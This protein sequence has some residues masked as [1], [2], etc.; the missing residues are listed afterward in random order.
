MILWSSRVEEDIKPENFVTESANQI[1]HDL[2]E[3]IEP[4]GQGK[5]DFPLLERNKKHRTFRTQFNEF[6]INWASSV[7]P[8]VKD[9]ELIEKVILPWLISMTSAAYRPIRYAATLAILN[10]IQGCCKACVSMHKDLETASRVMNSSKKAASLASK[11]SV[12]TL[13]GNCRN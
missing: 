5:S 8:A 10:I 13:S 9:L 1:L 3:R 2:Q 4:S 6:W 7:L 11:K 12:E